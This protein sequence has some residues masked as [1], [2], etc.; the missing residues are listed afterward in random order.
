MSNSRFIYSNKE[1]QKKITL[2]TN[3]T[4]RDVIKKNKDKFNDFFQKI[5]CRV[6]G[7][8]EIKNRSKNASNING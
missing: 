2:E 3:D 8:L 4:E 5:I 1:K 7:D 6:E